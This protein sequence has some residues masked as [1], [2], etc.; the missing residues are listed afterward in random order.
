[1]GTAAT[2][3][4]KPITQQLAANTQRAAHMRMMDLLLN[5]G[6]MNVA[7]KTTMLKQRLVGMSSWSQA[8]TPSIADS[9]KYG[10]ASNTRGSSFNYNT[11]SYYT[12]Y[13]S[14]NN[15]MLEY[16][17]SNPDRIDVKADSIVRYGDD[18]TGIVVVEKQNFSYN[19]SN[20]IV[21]YTDNDYTSTPATQDRYIHTYDAQGRLSYRL[22]ITDGDT[23]AREFFKY[24]TQG[25]LTL[26]SLEQYDGVN[27]WSP[28]F[29]IV[30]TYDASGNPTKISLQADV[31][32]S[33]TIVPV[34]TYDNT[35]YSNNTIK[36]S[37]FSALQTFPGSI[38]PIYA[39][40]FGYASGITAYFN[41]LQE[42]AYDNTT[43]TWELS[44]RQS[45][46]INTQGL[47]DT[48]NAQ[49]W[50]GTQWQP[51]GK[52][53]YTYN[54][55]NNPVTD[56]AYS[57]GTTPDNITTYYY[58]QYNDPTSVGNTPAVAQDIRIYPNP[59]TG[60]MNINWSNAVIGAPVTISIVGMNGQMVYSE[61]L[62]WNQ[63]VQ[64]VSVGQL[65]PGVYALVITDQKGQ[66][67]FHQNI[68]KQ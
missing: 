23:S 39:D 18:G 19:S 63:A 53:V 42:K 26:D 48:A 32:G 25:K 9:A 31:T 41:Y 10:Y 22:N 20:K 27:I 45:R 65:Q 24:N 60:N 29:K 55:N 12:S 66:Q 11:M 7:Q 38:E 5:R 3:Q 50:D 44:Y 14:L 58:E 33:G 62:R 61:S 2:A 49:T 6:D 57:T 21:D 51:Y 28:A 34:I 13:P 68:V 30:Y 16:L 15:L 52:N 43:A 8:G 37:L 40:S 56:K 46:H 1:M 4:K 64:Q 36:T 59:T 35:F 17:A 47:P 54:S 67:V